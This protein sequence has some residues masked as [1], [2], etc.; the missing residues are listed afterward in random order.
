[1]AWV[2]GVKI[3]SATIA[4]DREAGIVGSV[5]HEK[6]LLGKFPETIDSDRQ[7]I[8]AEKLIWPKTMEPASPTRNARSLNTTTSQALTTTPCGRTSSPRLLDPRRRSAMMGTDV[9]IGSDGNPFYL[10]MGRCTFLL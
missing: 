2:L 1:M 7:R 10:D 9:S 4:P 6:L 5:S 3:R 8:R